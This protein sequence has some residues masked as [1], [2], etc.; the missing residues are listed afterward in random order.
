VRGLVERELLSLWEATAA[1]PLVRAD[2]LLAAARPELAAAER[3]ALTVGQRDAALLELHALTFGPRLEG[4]VRCPECDE[5]LELELDDE[6]VRSIL[7]GEPALGEQELSL[8]GCELRFRPL[9]CGDLAALAGARGRDE[10]RLALVERCVLESSVGPAELPEEVLAALAARLE[11]CDPQAEIGVLVGCLACG[12]E[13]RA[14]LDI[15]AFL[16]AGIDAAAPRLLEEV[17]VLA[18]SYGWSEGEVLA[19]SRPRRE[20]YLELAG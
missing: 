17:H 10:A 7:D 11:S 3:D 15:S 4:F 19:L 18:R 16:S 8:A 2:A 6:Q 13:W 1:D 9:T 12:T 14:L 20:L 5:P